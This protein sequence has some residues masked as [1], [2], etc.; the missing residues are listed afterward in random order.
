MFNPPRLS[1]TEA[2]AVPVARPNAPPGLKLRD[3]D[4][5]NMH[6]L[7]LKNMDGLIKEAKSPSGYENP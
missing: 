5:K 6:N 7:F 2:S 3:M 1:T 4:E